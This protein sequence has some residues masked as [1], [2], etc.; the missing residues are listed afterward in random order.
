MEVRHCSEESAVAFGSEANVEP[1]CA[2]PGHG[3]PVP[4]RQS[5]MV[6]DVDI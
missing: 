6:I 1:L 2:E 4:I 3:D 5:G